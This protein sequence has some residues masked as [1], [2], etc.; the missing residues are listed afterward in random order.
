MGGWEF[1]RSAPSDNVMVP[2][3]SDPF[4]SPKWAPPVWHMP[5]MLV[6][7]VNLVR[8][9]V[10]LALVVIRH[11]AIT[12][13]VAVLGWLAYA[14]GWHVLALLAGWVSLGLGTWAWFGWPSFLRRVLRPARARWRYLMVYR[15]NW[16]PV[17]VMSGLAFYR[18]AREYLPT[19]L[20]VEVTKTTDRVLV[21]ML[22][23]QAPSIWEDHVENLAHGFGSV[24]CRIRTAKRPNSRLRRKRAGQDW[25]GHVWLE[26]V[27]DD[28]LGKPLSGLPVAAVEHDVDLSRL[29]VGR[30][31]D[32]SPWL[33]RLLGTH[34][35]I[36]GA[37]G[38]GKGSVLW[39]LVR[40]M[41]PAMRA[42]LVQVWGIDPKRM[43]LAF[44]R[45]IFNRYSDDTNGGM[46]ELLEAAVTEMSKR[47]ARFGGVTRTFLPTLA[48]PFIVVMVD[49]LAFLTAYCPDR[50]LRRR[51]LA[52]LSTLTSQG[53]SVGLCVVGALQDPRKDVINIRNLFPTRIALRLDESEQVDMVLGDGAYDRGALADQISPLPEVGAGVGY[54]RLEDTPDPVRVRAGWVSDTDIAAMSAYLAEAA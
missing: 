44:G 11:W 17:M 23:G 29:P 14:A 37:T 27:R 18:N 21:K 34:L 24:T 1:R 41:L 16:R 15:R 38:A 33:V 46:V 4:E 19:I 53:R 6:V 54:I 13:T 48:D 49:E 42:G 40:A 25:P 47:A 43:E 28:A 7:I 12:A 20:R 3:T 36:A 39:S 52:A 51:A 26:L 30:R 10:A 9:I 45:A 2:A 8:G 5:P 22:S 32:S 50:D 35:L 31:E